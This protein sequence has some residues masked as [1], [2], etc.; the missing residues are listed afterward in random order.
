MRLKADELFRFV[1]R[2][3]VDLRTKIIELNLEILELETIAMALRSPDLSKPSIGKDSHPPKRHLYH[4]F[5]K[6]EKKTKMRDNKQVIIDFITDTIY[7][8]DPTYRVYI[9]EIY[10]CENTY[11]NL[12]KQLEVSD[13]ALRR[14]LCQE[15][16]SNFTEE[17]AN[18][19]RLLIAKDEYLSQKLERKENM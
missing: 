18:E 2:Y 1:A 19:L 13:R 12:A 10:L 5:D 8:F 17:K 3:C 6:L 16:E 14:D 15:I 7:D 9:A 11:S 4:I